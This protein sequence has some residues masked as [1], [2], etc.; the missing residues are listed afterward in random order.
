MNRAH[1]MILGKPSLKKRSNLR[2][3][4]YISMAELPVQGGGTLKIKKNIGD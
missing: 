2:L 1:L 4:K 3:K